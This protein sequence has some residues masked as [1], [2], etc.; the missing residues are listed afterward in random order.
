MGYNYKVPE[1]W[2]GKYKSIKIIGDKSGGSTTRYIINSKH[3]SPVQNVKKQLGIPLKII[4]IIRNP[5]D[6]ISTMVT[7]TSNRNGKKIDSKLLKLKIEH[8]F[9][10][11]A[12][13]Q[14]IIKNHPK[15]VMDVKLENFIECPENYLAKICLFLN[16]DLPLN[17]LKD[18][19]SIVWKK[20]SKTRFKLQD[21]WTDVEIRYTMER[22]KEFP[23]LQGYKF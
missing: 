22:I 6:N 7:R 4:H 9:K 13:N 5:F 2:Q 3:A 10:M 19:A 16:V 1:Q 17:Y 20:E 15:E 21:L 14:L 12:Q 23:F 18:C 11:A 8:Y